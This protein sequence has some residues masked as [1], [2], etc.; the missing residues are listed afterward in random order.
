[1]RDQAP[2]EDRTTRRARQIQESHAA[3]GEFVE[4]FELLVTHL[5]SGCG[6]FIPVRQEL[7]DIILHHDAMTA[8][9][10]FDIWRA[11]ASVTRSLW[12]A[13]TP[14]KEDDSD[15]QM[16]NAVMKYIAK[17]FD[18][19]MSNRNMLLHGTWF[20]GWAS[21]TDEDFSHIDLLK[22]KVKATGL[23]HL[24]TPKTKEEITTMT[25][26]IRALRPLIVEASFTVKR[27]AR[28]R[29]RFVQNGDKW[30]A[31]KTQA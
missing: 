16:M 27:N 30:L 24:E 15:K 26:Q 11:L 21:A 9:P 4:A 22:A 10:L 23:H 12:S 20:I 5:R 2:P 19:A 17:E 7:L 8:K 3:I 6:E 25:Q 14:T 31:P 18:T 28:F 1:M 29:D 13:G